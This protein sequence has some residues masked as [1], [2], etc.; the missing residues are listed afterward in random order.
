MVEE[1][2]TM[3]R[4][5]CSVII[6]KTVV[7]QEITVSSWWAILTGMKD[8]EIILEQRNLQGWLQMFKAIVF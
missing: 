2:I 6:V 1:D 5:H 7:T 3:Q 4:V 8:P